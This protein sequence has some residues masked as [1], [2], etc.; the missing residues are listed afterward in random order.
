MKE[1]EDTPWTNAT[2]VGVTGFP[3]YKE[4]PTANAK[5]SASLFAQT[6]NNMVLDFE[7]DY[8]AAFMKY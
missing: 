4:K 8:A 5:T 2:L 7:F 1:P 6:M 3:T